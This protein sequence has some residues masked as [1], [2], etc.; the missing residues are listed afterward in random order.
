M[1]IKTREHGLGTTFAGAVGCCC[2]FLV[3]D[4]K[5][6]QRNSPSKGKHLVFGFC[7]IEDR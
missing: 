1:N 6:A 7:R 5:A 2:W 3:A 4:G